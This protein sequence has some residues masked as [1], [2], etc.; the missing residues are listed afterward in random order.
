MVNENNENNENPYIL[1]FYRDFKI[2]IM[3]IQNAKSQSKNPIYEQELAKL[4]EAADNLL[5]E[6]LENQED[7]RELLKGTSLPIYDFA[8]SQNHN[9]QNTEKLSELNKAVLDLEKKL[10]QLLKLNKND[11]LIKI[12]KLC[13]DLKNLI[14]EYT[15]Q[16]PSLYAKAYSE[17]PNAK[18]ANNNKSLRLQRRPRKYAPGAIKWDRGKPNVSRLVELHEKKIAQSAGNKKSRKVNKKKKKISKRKGNLKKKSKK[19]KKCK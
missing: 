17:E 12:K 7:L 13:V 9:G 6:F 2:L 16:S 18:P 8:S 3:A 5:D 11:T 14:S 15:E 1:N 10:K 19:N 4:L